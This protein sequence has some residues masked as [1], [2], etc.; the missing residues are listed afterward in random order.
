M[1]TYAEN[2]AR[3]K[4]NR[5]GY[6]A[7]NQPSTGL[8][9]LAQEPAPKSQSIDQ[10][11]NTEAARQG[12]T[13]TDTTPGQ[14]GGLNT[15]TTTPTKTTATTNTT[16][17]STTATTTNTQEAAP[18]DLR[19]AQAALSAYQSPGT[20]VAPGSDTTVP[21]TGP[22]G[23]DIPPT[24][25]TQLSDVPPIQTDQ[26][27]NIV[28]GLAGLAE[29]QWGGYGNTPQ[30]GGAPPD[31]AGNVPTGSTY[32]PYT[33]WNDATANIY[34]RSVQLQGLRG[35]SQLADDPQNEQRI[36]QLSQDIYQP[37]AQAINK[38]A[39]LQQQ[40]MLEGTF[41]RGVGNSTMTAALAGQLGQARE[42]ALGNAQQNAYVAAR[43]QANQDL[44]AYQNLAQ[45][46]FG[47][48]TSGL[49][50]E[51]N[52]GLA[53]AQ[54][55]M[56]AGQF[57]QGMQ[58]T[59]EQNDANRALQQAM[60]SSGFQFTGD[61]AALQRNFDQNMATMGY[62]VQAGSQASNQRFQAAMQQSQQKWQQGQTTNNYAFQS[63]MLTAQQ[64]YDAA[65]LLSQ[66]NYQTIQDTRQQGF[67]SQMLGSQQN[68]TAIENAKNQGW[69]ATQ[70]EAQRQLQILLQ[71]MQNAQAGDAQAKA[72][73]NGNI[74]AFIK[75]LVGIF[76]GITTGTTPNQGVG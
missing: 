42:Q 58:F 22:S 41:G 34:N 52:V 55:Q 3:A 75:G 49:Q 57:G 12:K 61:Q 15:L 40:Q 43:G 68:F 6:A 67:E 20:T 30:Y 36:T 76:G 18:V 33:L 1:A 24:T 71:T 45:G 65:R 16:P 72:M 29:K 8:T 50:A 14:L 17:A 46:L 51:A 5:A 70:N 37:Q 10:L 62:A 44:A 60:Q 63:A 48:G 31:T 13:V 4:A 21:G 54:N 66:Q 11:F 73:L 32:T 7:Y 26:W 53:N 39:D 28:A 23:G 27:G 38:A 69:Q 2:I 19:G 47:A 59:A 56:A 64:Q 74:S 9:G 35:L 25:L